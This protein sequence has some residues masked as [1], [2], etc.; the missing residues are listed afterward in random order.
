MQN[1]PGD[2]LSKLKLMFDTLN[3]ELTREEFVS[4]FKEVVDVLKKT[5][6]DSKKDL[7][8]RMDARLASIKNG[9]DGRDGKDGAKGEKGDKGDSIVGPPGKDGRDGKD[10]SPDTGDQIIQKINSANGLIVPEAIAGFEDLRK[11]VKE[12]TGNTTRIGWGAHPL[13]IQG[14]GQVIDKNTRV[15]NFAGA[16]LSSVVRSKGGVVTVTLAGGTGTVYSETP[17][18]LIDGINTS[19]TVAHDITNVYNM[20]I[21]G[22]FIHPGEYSTSGGTI[23]MNTPLPAGLSGTQFTITYS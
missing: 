21:N 2:K 14:L 7:E 20:A 8:R 9:K 12:K 22:Q 4:A 6:A 17:S 23:T 15:L 18:G 19:Y 3:N 1:M 11:E 13:V 5:L 10:G 16:G